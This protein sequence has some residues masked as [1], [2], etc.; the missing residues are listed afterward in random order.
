MV[1]LSRAYPFKFFKGCLPQILPGPYFSPFINV[2]KT[3]LYKFL[4]D[5]HQ[6]N[7]VLSTN[8]QSS[9]FTVKLRNLVT[10][11]KLDYKNSFL[12]HINLF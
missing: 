9:K 7:H 5:I 10:I 12:S 8:F 3:Y 1:C 6:Q 2:R 4:H 11:E